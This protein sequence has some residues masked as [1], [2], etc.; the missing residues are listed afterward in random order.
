MRGGQGGVPG[1]EIFRASC[2][3]LFVFGR[4]FTHP[5]AG[6]V[7]TERVRKQRERTWSIARRLANGECR[8]LV[9][10]MLLSEGVGAC[11]RLYDD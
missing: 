1:R 5:I 7:S 4:F 6:K 3:C 9:R 11:L 8:I 2:S 10:S